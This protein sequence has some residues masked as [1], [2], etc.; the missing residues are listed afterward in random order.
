MVIY[1]AGYLAGWKP[2][3]LVAKA[4]RLKAL[5]VDVRL[6]PLSRVAGFSEVDLKHAMGDSYIWLR[7]WGNLNYRSG[8]P[9]QLGDFEG[10]LA[11]LGGRAE[12]VILLCACRDVN[13]CHRKVVAEKLAAEWGCEIVHLGRPGGAK[14]ISDCSDFGVDMMATA[15]L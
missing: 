4:K 9:V 5:V 12:N 8:G 13:V 7:E 3:A 6:V 15:P 2:E 10:G 1:T 14:K 11:K